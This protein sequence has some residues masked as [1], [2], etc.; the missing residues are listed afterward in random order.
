M[1]DKTLAVGDHVIFDDVECEITVESVLEEQPLA[2][3]GYIFF[4]DQYGDRRLAEYDE[5]DWHIMN[6]KF[7]TSEQTERASHILYGF[8]NNVR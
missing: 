7:L 3:D 8:G 5:P 4:I 1:S 2:E 6:E